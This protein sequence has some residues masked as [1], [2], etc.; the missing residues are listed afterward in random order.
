MVMDL[1]KTNAV[2]MLTDN[3]LTVDKAK[4]Y[5]LPSKDIPFPY[6][7]FK[8]IGQPPEVL[9]ELAKVIKGAGKELFLESI[10][11][12]REEYDF[13][14]EFSKNA[15]VDCVLGTLYDEKLHKDLE[16]CG[17]NYYPFIGKTP[18][19]PAQI[20]K[21]MDEIRKDMDDAMKAGVK[22]VSIPAYMHD[23]YTGFEILET[24]RK[25]WPDVPILV[26][27]R[28]NSEERIAEMF[29][30]RTSYTIGGAIFKKQFAPEGSYTDNVQGLYD[31]NQKIG[32]K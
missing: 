13:L 23:D 8:S 31:L 26:A 27:G 28:V 30:L 2:I 32:G 4:E 25:E 9:Y 6:W 12:T 16:A 22:G 19:Y 29:K 7:G 17:T 18:G 3:D 21:S 24:L 14:A 10:I 1:T 11:Y 20:I 5:F 15:G